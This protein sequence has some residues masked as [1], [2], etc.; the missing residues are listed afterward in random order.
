MMYELGP[1]SLHKLQT[2]KSTAGRSPYVYSPDGRSFAVAS[3]VEIGVKPLKSGA[4]VE[5]RYPLPRGTEFDQM[6]WTGE[7]SLIV[8][9]RSSVEESASLVWI[10]T[11]K[12][13]QR[14]QPAP[15]VIRLFGW[16]SAENALIVS[17]VDSESGGEVSSLL[18]ASGESRP[19]RV[20]EAHEAGEYIRSF[21]AESRQSV[22]ELGREDMGDPVKVLILPP[23]DAPAVP[24]LEGFPRIRELS[25]SADGRWVVFVDGGPVE[26][27]ET[28]G[29]I[30]IV[31]FAGKSPARLLKSSPTG[32]RFARPVLGY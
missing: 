6:I 3:D 24:W 29:D 17:K 7:N 31:P 2:L 19:F 23:G 10:D 8:L 18:T 11:V 12:R 16:D 14:V 26:E 13:T 21:H 32:L 1:S 25:A 30:Y 15:G 22:A 28:G 4:T 27:L 20:A 9:V 5:L